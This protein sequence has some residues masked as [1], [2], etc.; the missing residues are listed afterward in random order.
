M[1]RPFA[2]FLLVPLLLLAGCGAIL[3]QQ[4]PPIGTVEEI[5][6]LGI[7]N[8]RFWPDGRPDAIQRE[9]EMAIGREAARLPRGPRPPV[10]FLAISGGADNGAYGAG[11]LTG[12]TASGA[13]P[14]F[15]VVTGISAGALIAPFAFLGPDYDAQL[16]EVFTG[17]LPTDVLVIPRQMA[18]AV[19]LVFGE[20]LA[21]ISPLNRLIARHLTQEMLAAIGREYGRG[22][23]LLVGTTNLDLQR[24]VIWNIGAIAASG[25]P[26]ALDLV[27]SIL[28]ASASIPG[29]FPPVL[30][31]VEHAGLRYQEMHVDGGAATQVFLYP[32][33]LR[34]RDASGVGRVRT[35]HVVRNGRIDVEGSSTTRG[36]LSITRRAASTLLHFSGIGDINRIYLTTQRDGVGFRLAYIGADFQ[37]SRREPFDPPFMQALF[38]Y[39]H[40]Q[41]LAGDRWRSEPPVVGNLSPDVT[42]APA[43][44]QRVRE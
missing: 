42:P 12:W 17:V 23:L 43:T 39:G 14:E 38:D 4:A 3:R 21:D 11:L 15:N 2:V 27:R 20:A 6:V 22:R 37:A 1:R 9:S 18:A 19:S 7:P 44:A 10:H 24:P 5:A 25:H 28:L 32:P 33:M 34:L 35:A 13:R 31:D 30:I 26:D 40:A 41:G 8:A 29:A 16:R 36:V